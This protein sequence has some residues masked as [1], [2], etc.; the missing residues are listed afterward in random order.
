MHKSQIKVDAGRCGG[1][2]VAVAGTGCHPVLEWGINVEVGGALVV[3]AGHGE[4]DGTI[5][6]AAGGARP[7]TAARAAPALAAAILRHQRA[8]T[9][10]ILT[11]AAAPQ[12]SIRTLAHQ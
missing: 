12:Y 10:A 8:H 7:P 5:L 1:V 6:G 3:G 2:V 4:S 9:A 11:S